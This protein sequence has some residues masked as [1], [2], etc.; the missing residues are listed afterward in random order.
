MKEYTATNATVT[1]PDGR[2]WK[3]SSDITEDRS[4]YSKAWHRMY[5][6]KRSESGRRVTVQQEGNEHD[7]PVTVMTF[8]RWPNS[9]AKVSGGYI[10]I[11]KA[12]FPKGYKVSDLPPL[13]GLDVNLD[14]IIRNI[15]AKGAKKKT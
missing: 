12:M 3:A 2:V 14:T 8:D 5:G 1:T 6:P 9:I 4:F 7:L 15:F 13:L 10:A 11:L